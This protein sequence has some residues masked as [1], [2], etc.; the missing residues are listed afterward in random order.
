MVPQQYLS[1]HPNGRHASE[2]R[3]QVD[4]Y[5]WRQAEISN[6]IG[7]YERYLENHPNGQFADVAKARIAMLQANDRANRR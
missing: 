2:A 5:S 4:E 6:S 3:T 1:T 7:G